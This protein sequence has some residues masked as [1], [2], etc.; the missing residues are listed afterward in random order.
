MSSKK[1]E[2]N[3]C[4]ETG[5]FLNL[6]LSEAIFCDRFSTLGGCSSL[7]PQSSRPYKQP[8]GL[9]LKNPGFYLMLKK[10]KPKPPNN[11]TLASWAF[12]SWELLFC[13]GNYMY[14]YQ[15]KTASDGHLSLLL[16]SRKLC[17]LDAVI[18][19]KWWLSMLQ[20]VILACKSVLMFF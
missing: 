15:R 19:D 2:M 6:V 16:C 7:R 20:V 13:S 12:S 1:L 3:M 14:W 11:K 10:K 17:Y 5:I 9:H 4:G 18:L 8:I